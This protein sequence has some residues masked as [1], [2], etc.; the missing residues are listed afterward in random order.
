MYMYITHIPFEVIA[1]SGF[2][3]LVNEAG[4]VMG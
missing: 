2:C 3:V 1:S 4:S